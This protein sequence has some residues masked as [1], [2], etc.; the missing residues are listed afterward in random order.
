MDRQFLELMGKLFI[1]TAKGQK[2]LED[3]VRWMGG[4]FSGA[5]EVTKIFRN[6]YGLNG[7]APSSAEHAGAWEKASEQFQKSFREWLDL[8]NVVPRSAFEKLEN[9]C[10]S[11]EEKVRSQEET[12]RHLQ[13]LLRKESIP[14]DEAVER[15]ID[16]MEK[17]GRQFQALM[18]SVGKAF[19]ND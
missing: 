9:Q 13:G 3:M 5:D 12:I 1:E 11:L 18:D 10:A 6:F 15:F 14:Y 17:Q 16:S 7:L 4:G 19:N 2:H 8:M